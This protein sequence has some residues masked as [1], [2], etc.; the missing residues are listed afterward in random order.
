MKTIEFNGKNILFQRINGIYWI[1]IKSVC[2]SLIVDYVRQYKNIQDDPILG[3]VL[4]NQT[5]QIPG[6]QTRKI[7]CLPEEYIYGWIFS[8]KSKSSELIEYKREC[9]HI[10]YNHFHGTITRR[11][12]LYSELSK[13]R[14]RVNEIERNLKANP[15]FQEWEES[16]MQVVRL[17]K[18]IKSTSNED[19]EDIFKEENFE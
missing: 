5:M 2:E 13:A 9:Y 15:E 19:M 14:K 16:K 12:E 18:N 11:A 3:P 6:D 10:L 7:A 1:S 4:S 8:I 17:W